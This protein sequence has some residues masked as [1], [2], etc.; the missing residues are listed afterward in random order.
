MFHD[1]YI[2]IDVYVET[3]HT[4]GRQKF[5]IRDV[6]RDTSRQL[7]FENAAGEIINV[8]DYF[9]TQYQIKLT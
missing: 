8:Y 6:V 4:K 9:N 2:L 1:C 3:I 7:R 5:F